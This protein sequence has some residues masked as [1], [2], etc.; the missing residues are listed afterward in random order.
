M[1][2]DVIFEILLNLEPEEIIKQKILNKKFKIV[3]ESNSLWKL[4]TINKFKINLDNSYEQI[5]TEF[6][7]YLE[8]II[9]LLKL[10][11][12]HEYKHESYVLELFVLEIIN[13]K[14]L[15]NNLIEFYSLQFLTDN[16]LEILF[17]KD[18]IVDKLYIK[19]NLY[20]HYFLI[21]FY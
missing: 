15:F 11:I 14:I 16:M 7:E 12:L 8:I 9:T 17:D 3:A 1:D 2:K 5:F 20:Y 18:K 21:L 13:N 4:M 19:E 10:N 6:S